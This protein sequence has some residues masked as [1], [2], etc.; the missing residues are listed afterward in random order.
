MPT[1]ITIARCPNGTHKSPNGHCE[2]VVPHTGLP[3]CPNGFHRSPSRDCE[4][5]SSSPSSETNDA[6]GSTN[7]DQIDNSVPPLSSPSTT[8]S[9]SIPTSS[10][11]CDQLLLL[12]V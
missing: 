6:S 10:D 8:S 4:Q 1:S 2:T 11:Q 9:S 3:R 5:V 12:V 7:F